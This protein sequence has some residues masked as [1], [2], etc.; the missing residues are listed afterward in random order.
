[1]W[2]YGHKVFFA[3]TMT[4]KLDLHV[5]FLI[6]VFLR[7]SAFLT[8]IIFFLAGAFLIPYFLLVII[9]GVPLFFLECAVGQF[10]GVSGF[11]AWAI[12]PLFQGK[13]PNTCPS[14]NR[15]TNLRKNE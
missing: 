12:C 3:Q 1:M 10:M 13:S 7:M 5:F 9:G 8:L 2:L 14:A 4:Y 6:F 11:R 15:F